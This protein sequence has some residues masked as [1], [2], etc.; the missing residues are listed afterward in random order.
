MGAKGAR[1]LKWI[2][3]SMLV[4][5]VL[6]WLNACAAATPAPAPAATQ[7]PAAAAPT[8]AP[9]VQP[10]RAP[11]PTAAPTQ[12]AQEINKTPAATAIA[13]SPKP[14]AT[15]IAPSPTQVIEDRLVEVEWP[16][17]MRLGES[18]VVRLSLIPSSEGYVLKTEFEE[19][20]AITQ[21]LQVAHPAGYDLFA[22][23]RLDGV[24]FDIAPNYEEELFVQSGEPVTWRWSLTPHSP[25]QQRLSVLL[26]LRWKLADDP[27]TTVHETVAYSRGLDIPVTSFLGLTQAQAMSTGWFGIILGGLLILTML[28]I[29]PRSLEAR[30]HSPLIARSPNTL[31]AIELSPGVTVSETERTLLQSL[32]QSYN[33]LIVEGEFHS[34]YSGARTFLVLP[35]RPDG[36]A[37]AHTIAKIGERRTIQREFSNYETFVKDT[38]PP[39]TARIQHA[40]VTITGKAAAPTK[41]IRSALEYAAIQYTFIGEPGSSPVSLGDALLKDPRPELIY[42]LFNNFGPNWWMQRSPYTFCLAVEYDRMLPTHLV[43]EPAETGGKPLDGRTLPSGLHLQIGDLVRLSHF[44]VTEQRADGES[45]SLLG[46]ALPGEPAMRVRWLGLRG[47]NQ[48][49]GR[50]I[51][52]R[53]TLLDEFVAGCDLFGIPDPLERLPDLLAETIKG[54][55]SIIHGDLN[56][57]NILIG[58]G[59]LVWLIDFAQTR[60]GHTL[61]DFAHL[62]AELIAQLIAPRIPE[63]ATY[64]KWLPGLMSGISDQDRTQTPVDDM[65]QAEQAIQSSKPLI[66]AVHEIARQ[67][68]FNPSQPREY[69]LAL[70]MACL[71]ALKFTNLQSH[72]KHILYLTAAYLVQTL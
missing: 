48:A 52:T 66:A 3:F 31:L 59:G 60:E 9:A 69:R 26:K 61:I 25:G 50:V 72:A 51:A 30:S 19:H 21:T 15:S 37:D 10:T 67:C 41:E 58:P 12:A 22:A 7:A 44:N 36:R 35:I 40:P 56:L 8:G 65:G 62:E 71:G 29:R 2:F 47:A 27:T 54:T 32:F 14:S 17:R 1:L 4:V 70:T 68:L 23:A 11:N 20:K 49:G 38:L 6:A 34:G 53:Q 46:E 57:E 64:L 63:A 24:G 42:K 5:F 28:F 33:R 13:I 18:D 55:R 16:R 43:I 45:L 39:I